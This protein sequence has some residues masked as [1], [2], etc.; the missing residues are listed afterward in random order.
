MIARIDRLSPGEGD[1]WRRIRLRALQEA[2]YAFGTTYAEA[3]QWTDARWEAQVV[4][5]ATFVAVLDGQDV[6]VARGASHHRSDARELVSMWVDPAARR[7]GIG[8][9]LIERVSA[10]ASAAGATMLV[11][12]VVAGNASA[13]ALYDKAG[14]VPLDGETTGECA[15]GEVR[16]VRS[17]A[18][19]LK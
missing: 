1:R 14:F 5:F 11:L 17:L 2:P 12:D 8:A 6:G 15:S 4:E 19:I 13:I 18:T 9:Q 7:M 10:W 16:F 3:S